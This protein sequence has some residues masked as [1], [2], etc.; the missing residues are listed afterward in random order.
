M[1]LK[2]K[3][4]IFKHLVLPQL[5]SAMTESICFVSSIYTSYLN[6]INY[7]MKSKS[8]E[9]LGQRIFFFFK[10][11]TIQMLLFHSMLSAYA[12]LVQTLYGNRK[13]KFHWF[14]QYCIAGWKFYLL[15]WRPTRSLTRCWVE[16]WAV[17]S[18]LV[19]ADFHN[20]KRKDNFIFFWHEWS[21]I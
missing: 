7:D 21:H 5:N 13:T 20:N 1:E 9:T 12:I 8:I 16:C 4:V 14:R 3:R 11:A 2:A 17:V 18:A 15:R 10:R 19:S 6:N